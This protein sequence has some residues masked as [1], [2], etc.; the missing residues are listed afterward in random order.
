MAGAQM[1]KPV[2]GE[3]ECEEEITGSHA[4]RDAYALGRDDDG[5]SP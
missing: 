3:R 2:E 1:M 4:T 5:G